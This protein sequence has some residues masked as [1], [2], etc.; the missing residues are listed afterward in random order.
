MTTSTI[1]N[2]LDFSE[3]YKFRGVLSYHPTNFGNR[4]LF[5]VINYFEY[6][7][8]DSVRKNQADFDHLILNRV[9]LYVAEE[10]Q[11]LDIHDAQNILDHKTELRKKFQYYLLSCKKEHISR[12]VVNI[13][14]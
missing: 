4:I 8:N 14:I 2:W 7:F 12:Y 13:N 10:M 11:K 9:L 6:I 1:E 3:S 5:D